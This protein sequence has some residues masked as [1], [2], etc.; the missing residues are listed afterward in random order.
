MQRIS[1]KIT[2]HAL[3]T[4]VAAKDDCFQKPF[5][6]IEAVRISKFIWQ[7]VPDCRASI[8]KSP[9]AV[10]AKSAARHS[11]TV[12]VCRASTTTA[13]SSIRGWDEVIHKVPRCRPCRHW[14]TVTP[15]QCTRSSPG[16]PASYSSLCN[17]VFSPRSNFPV[18]L[19]LRG[20]VQH[21]RTQH[22]TH[23]P[24]L[25]GGPS[26]GA[27]FNPLEHSIVHISHFC[28]VVLPQLSV[29][30]IVF[31]VQSL[32]AIK[33]ILPYQLMW[34]LCGYRELNVLALKPW[35]NLELPESVDT[36]L[37]D[38]GFFAVCLQLIIIAV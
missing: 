38:V 32:L 6:T 37:A 17:I 36:A 24:L 1:L 33:H 19:T 35:I 15:I 13:R 2:S 20:C 28:L 25:F 10:R 23:Q 29:T 30:F 7:R 31:L 21:I 18:S 8:I 9:A 34:L 22:C 3:V 11:E 5:K 26:I 12:R 16:H 4:L 14:Y 27:V